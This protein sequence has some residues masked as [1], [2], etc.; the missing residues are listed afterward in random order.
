MEH[1]KNDR[2]NIGGG[3]ARMKTRIPYIICLLL[4]IFIFRDSF[5]QR[6]LVNSSIDKNNI[7]IGEPIRLSIE[8]FLPTG[9]N[10]GWFSLDSIPHFE[11]ID[12]S[13]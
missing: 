1:Q 2:A 9:T 13:R 10:A 5:S 11:W 8:V 3:T 4:F 7:L 12:K 6:V